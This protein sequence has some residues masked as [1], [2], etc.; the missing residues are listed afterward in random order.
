MKPFPKTDTKHPNLLQIPDRPSGFSQMG[1]IDSNANVINSH[2]F[3]NCPIIQ[4]CVPFY[5]DL[6][7]MKEYIL[8]P[9]DAS[10]MPKDLMAL[11]NGF[12]GGAFFCLGNCE[13][14]LAASKFALLCICLQGF[15]CTL[16]G[17][18]KSST[19]QRMVTTAGTLLA[20][21]SEPSRSP[22]T[23]ARSTGTMTCR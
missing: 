23:K 12:Q 18:G 19:L 11:T 10:K 15:C 4:G 6:E 20:L 3:V 9:L 8:K 16:V 5:M 21:L 13:C 17:P 7:F 2:N 22:A 1:G 14:N